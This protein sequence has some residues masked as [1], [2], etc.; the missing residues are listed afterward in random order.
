MI[1]ERRAQTRIGD[2]LIDEFQCAVVRGV[3]VDIERT[4]CHL[5]GSRPWFLCPSCGRRCSILYPVNCRHCLRL[6]YASEAKSV[7]DRHYQK[8][9][10]V[11][12]RLGQTKGGIAA[13]FPPKPKR[14]R[15]HTYL[16]IRREAS[17]LELGICNTVLASLPGRRL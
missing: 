3:T 8:A 1:C 13:P 10:R 9:E 14:M 11:R 5:G 17:Q 15:W 12:A 2:V 7:L 6:S 16:R 4:A